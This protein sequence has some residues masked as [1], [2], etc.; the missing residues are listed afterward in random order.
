MGFYKIPILRLRLK[1]ERRNGRRPLRN[2]QSNISPNAVQGVMGS[3]WLS[4]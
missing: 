3:Y 1:M 2:L 4:S